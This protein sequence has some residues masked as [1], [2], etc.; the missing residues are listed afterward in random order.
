MDGQFSI[1]NCSELFRLVCPLSWDK[2]QRTDDDTV[3]Y[4]EV[5]KKNVY[6]CTSPEQVQAHSFAND[7][8]AVHVRMVETVS[9]LG[10]L[11]GNPR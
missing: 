9:D 1:D 4:C 2:L 3:R 10:P 8:I 5:C 6:L 11:M 7:C